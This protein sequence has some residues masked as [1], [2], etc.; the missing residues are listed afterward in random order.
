M[1]ASDSIQLVGIP[2]SHIDS[3]LC[4]LLVGIDGISSGTYINAHKARELSHPV[5][6]WVL[7][8][9]MSS[10]FTST[11]RISSAQSVGGY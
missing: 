6:W 8:N 2:C 10:V 5:L 9:S 7:T 3:L 4:G 1:L 11:R